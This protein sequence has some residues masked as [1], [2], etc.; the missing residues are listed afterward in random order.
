MPDSA[1]IIQLVTDL[2]MVRGVDTVPRGHLRLE[3]KFQYPDRSSVDLFILNPPQGVLVP[4]APVLSDLGQ[5]MTWLADLQVRP[6]QSKKRQRFLEDTLYVLGVMQ[7]GGAL[8]TTFDV[9]HDSLEDA[10]IRLGQACV[11]VAD[12]SFT[13]R[14]NLQVNA[15]EELEELISDADLA[16]ETN[17]SLPGRH[18]TLVVVDFLVAGRR[19]KSA[20]LTLAAQYPGSAHTSANEVFRKLYDLD[21]PDRAEQRVTV[22]DDRYDVYRS[23]DLERIRDLGELIALS[24]RQDVVAL[25]A[26]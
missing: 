9:N 7:N 4:S 8:E 23:E 16:Y 1:S 6:W 22:Y 12:L 5:T 10:V 18:G 25:L 13:R 3:T 2:C 24:A 26:A 15:T 19:Q 11:R 20:V 14:A 21:T 17:A